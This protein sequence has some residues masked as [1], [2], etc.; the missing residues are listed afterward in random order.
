MQ[1]PKSYTDAGALTILSGVMNVLVGGLLC[2]SLLM[3]CVGV[4]WVIPMGVGVFQIVVGI[5]M[6]KGQ[7]SS[8]A[9]YIG[10]VG[11]IAGVFNFNPLAIGAAVLAMLK[12]KEPE[13]A[14]YLS[15]S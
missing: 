7:R 8:A 12:V 1:A 6:Q 2:L 3:L 9:G 15:G 13:V 10:I 14:G 4:F 11:L 5:S